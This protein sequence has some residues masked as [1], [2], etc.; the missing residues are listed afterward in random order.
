MHCL[1]YGKAIGPRPRRV[2]HRSMTLASTFEVA[3]YEYDFMNLYMG[4]ILA[5]CYDLRP[6]SVLAIGVP[7]TIPRDR[8][9]IYEYN[10]LIPACCYECI[11]DA[12][13][14]RVLSN[15]NA[16]AVRTAFA[17]VAASL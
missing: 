2:S 15:A 4:R 7:T 17:D 9:I 3:I 11:Q 1:E 10:N 8:K 13:S 5:M 16:V 6:T 12:K 14:I